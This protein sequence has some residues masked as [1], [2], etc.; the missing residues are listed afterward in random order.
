VCAF[1]E[2]MG[3]SRVMTVSTG[4]RT[5]SDC[6]EHVGI[7]DEKETQQTLFFPLAMC[8][9]H[10]AM[11]LACCTIHLSREREEKKIFDETKSKDKTYI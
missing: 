10:S 8:S 5:A 2:A 4:T 9:R 7:L 3:S 11:I 1:M 6:A